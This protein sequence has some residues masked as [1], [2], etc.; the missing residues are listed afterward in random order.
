MSFT[1][2]S[3]DKQLNLQRHIGS[4]GSAAGEFS[5]P[6]SICVLPDETLIIA[7]MNNHR[8][9]LLDVHGAH[10]QTIG[11]RGTGDGAI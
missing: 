2:Q 3:S 10:L 4:R 8:V 1:F 5:H 11:A 9:Q 6:K 7:D